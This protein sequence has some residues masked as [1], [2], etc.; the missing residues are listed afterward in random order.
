MKPILF[1]IFSLIIFRMIF[2][3]ENS[4]AANNVNLRGAYTVNYE[5]YVNSLGNPE[6]K[7]VTSGFPDH[8][9]SWSQDGKWIVFFRIAANNGMEI[10]KWKTAICVIKPDGSDLRT[11]TSGKFADFNPTWSREGSNFIIINR[12]DPEKNRNFI[13]R[14]AIDSHP[15]DEVLLSDPEYS[16]FGFSCLKDGRMIVSSGRGGGN[17]YSYMFSFSPDNDGYYHP[18]F[19]YILTT[20]PGKIGKY[21]RLNFQ[22]KLDA[23]PSRLTLSPGET[24]IAYEYDQS[25]G[26]FSYEGH[27][28]VTAEIDIKKLIISNALVFSRSRAD[29]EELYPA[30]TCDEN[31]IVYFSNREGRHQFYCF[32]FKTKKTARIS[33]NKYADYRYFCGEATPK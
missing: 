25:W 26:N 8:K 18:P 14:T 7:P 1:F 22:Y 16:E 27:P 24:R 15:G 10:K 2:A 23:L 9:P 21:E 6:G 32:E 13:Y 17:N 19:I 31:A 30:F 3:D 11:L 20:E 5:I 28:L 4:T 33:F 12:F 29:V